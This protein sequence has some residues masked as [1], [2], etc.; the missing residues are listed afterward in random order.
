MGNYL[1]DVVLV[2]YEISHYEAEL[3]CGEETAH[4]VVIR[5]PPQPGLDYE[6]VSAILPGDEAV[7]AHPD[8]GESDLLHPGRTS[9]PGVGS[10]GGAVTLHAGHH[11]C[12]HHCHRH[13]QEVEE[14]GHHVCEVRRE[15]GG[16]EMTFLV[17]S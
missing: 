11:H 13:H 7:P 4:L 16:E 10:Q 5:T 15:R 3:R 12:H 9:E 17:F 2:R 6:L 14:G 1:E 8:T